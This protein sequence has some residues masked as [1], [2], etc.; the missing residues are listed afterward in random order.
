MTVKPSGNTNTWKILG[1]IIIAGLLLVIFFYLKKDD[2]KESLLTKQK[3]LSYIP[4]ITEVN[5]DP[6]EPT[7]T[8]SIRVLPVLKDRRMR[9][10]KFQY[11]WF[12]NGDE[13][14]GENKNRLDKKY[15]K[16]GDTVFCRVKGVRGNRYVSGEVKSSEVNI[17]NSLPIVNLSMVGSF[18]VPG[19]FRYTI[20][21]S[22][23]DDDTLTYRLVEPLNLGIDIDPETGEVVWDIE[24]RPKEYNERDDIET[25]SGAESEGAPGEEEEGRALPA[26][27]PERKDP[28]LPP[29]VR[30]V[31]EIIDSDGGSVISSISLNLLEG[32]EVHE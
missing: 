25:G 13:V 1:I 27:R 22:D 24:E 4:V 26:R 30:I 12:V 14:P 20:D 19:R 6:E 21:A 15:Y 17:K 10:V 31:F 23:P 28:G 8:D 29:V 5:I 3:S 32:G 9:H 16:K 7:A 11:Q 18:N 2:K